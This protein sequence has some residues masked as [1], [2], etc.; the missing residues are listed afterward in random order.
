MV[1]AL[2]E[3][4]AG[5]VLPHLLDNML[6]SA[7]GR[8]ILRERP[9]INTSTIDMAALARLPEN[10]FGRAYVTWLERCGVTPDTREP[11]RPPHIHPHN[12]ATAFSDHADH[13][14]CTTSMIPSSPTSCSDTASATTFTMRCAVC[15]SRSSTSSRS[16]CSSLR[17]LACRPRHCPPPPSFA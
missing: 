14:R 2:G 11:V 8:R 4:T 1:A 3:T 17:T 9:R 7:E 5:P 15:P 6:A 13:A 16:R 12:L 10:T